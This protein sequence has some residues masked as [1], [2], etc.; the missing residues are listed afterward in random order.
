[1]P[2]PF[3]AA[4]SVP[5]TPALT[6]QQHQALKRQ[7]DELLAEAARALKAAKALGGQLRGSYVLLRGAG[8][9]EP[10]AGSDGAV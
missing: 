2:P 7:R 10:A 5:A 1:M 8:D 4:D 3:V 9:H 6:P